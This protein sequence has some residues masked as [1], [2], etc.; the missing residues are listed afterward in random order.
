MSINVLLIE[1]DTDLTKIITYN[2]S[3]ENIN[4]SCIDDGDDVMYALD[5]STPDLIILD[6]ML[7]NITGLEL[8]KQ[9]K[10]SK[11]TKF[12][13]VVMLTALFEEE[14]K[15]KAFRYGA[16]DYISKPFS[17]KELI[18]RI[19]VIMKRYNEMKISNELIFKDLILK[20]DSKRVMRENKEIKLGPI[21][22]K[23]LEIFMTK[24]GRVYTRSQLLD[25]AWGSNVYVEERT[26]DVHIGRLRKALKKYS[27][28]D[29]FRTVRG[30][31]YSLDDST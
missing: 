26:V 15:L 28:V 7:P 25:L 27:K 18:A 16:D 4:T 17:V 11:K 23:L 12:I 14:N 30:S 9:I 10:S 21:E 2:L 5:S 13:P 24:P 31:G 22:F 3:K 8:L 19:K 20:K 29:P 6:W 1:D